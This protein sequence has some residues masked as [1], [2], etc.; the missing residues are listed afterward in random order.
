VTVRV[1]PTI[2]RRRNLTHE[3]TSHGGEEWHRQLRHLRSQHF[4]RAVIIDELA[5]SKAT[6]DGLARLLRSFDLE[7]F[8][9]V[10]IIDFSPARPLPGVP[11]YP[12]YRIP[13]PRSEH[14]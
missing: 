6:A 4:P 8:A 7:P 3:I 2:I 13:Y 1:P 14:G 12:L 10:P 9:Y 11:T 5:G